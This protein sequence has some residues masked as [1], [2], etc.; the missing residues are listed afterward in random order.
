M[1]FNICFVLP[2]VTIVATLWWFGDTAALKLTRGRLLLQ[3]YWPVLLATVA[4]IAGGFV[5]ALGVTG[6]AA[7]VHGRLGRFFKHVNHLLH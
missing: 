5:I 3:R 4:L 7:R 1:L 6:I 2:L